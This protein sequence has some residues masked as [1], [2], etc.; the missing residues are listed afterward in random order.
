MCDERAPSFSEQ[1]TTH[2]IVLHLVSNFVLVVRSFIKS[3]KVG[4]G[5]NMVNLGSLYARSVDC[6][7]VALLLLCLRRSNGRLSLCSALIIKTS[8]RS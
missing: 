1:R 2:L 7:I 6:V 5:F 4:V 3:D 8:S